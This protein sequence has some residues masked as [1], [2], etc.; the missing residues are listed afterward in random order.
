MRPFPFLLACVCFAQAPTVSVIEVYGLRKLTPAQIKES[1]GVAEGQML[2][3]S[4][5]LIE[6]RV[7]EIEG[8]AD[9]S[10]E[11]ACCDA[12][13]VTL[14]I[15]VLE[16]GGEAVSIHAEPVDTVELPEPIL[17]AYTRFLSEVR[18]AGRTGGG[19]ED[20]TQGH[21][22]LSAPAAREA[23]LAFIPIANDN[24]VL[25][26]D[27]LRNSN[28]PEHRAIAAYILGYHR[29]KSIITGDLEYA[30]HDPDE[31]V[32]ANAIRALSAIATLASR[33]KDK[34]L[35]M[36]A[37][38]LIGLLN[39]PVWTDRN[40]AAVALVTLTEGR[41]ASL[42]RLIRQ[43]AGSALLE[44]SRWKQ[45]EHALSAYILLGRTMNI[46]E[47]ELQAAWAKGDR[48]SIISRLPSA[49]KR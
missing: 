11:A 25:L 9:A 6:E 38:P 8:V 7:H 3:P 16:A 33:G 31:T 37:N 22:L 41:D 4:K 40:N 23:Q 27:V 46:P 1:A 18:E 45:P 10:V 32:R 21:S 44:M 42:L 2:P 19:T 28:N 39:S 36:D 24:L 48:E 14:Y 13:G 29:E 26:R 20:L 49:G 15:G 34:L 17:A 47:K 30:L 43:R 5:S 12:K 35:K